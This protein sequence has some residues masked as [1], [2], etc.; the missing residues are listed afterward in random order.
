MCSNS[1]TI[2]LFL[3]FLEFDNPILIGGFLRHPHGMNHRLGFLGRDDRWLF[4]LNNAAGEVVEFVLE[5]SSP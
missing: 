2:L 5:V 1:M 3:R 4:P